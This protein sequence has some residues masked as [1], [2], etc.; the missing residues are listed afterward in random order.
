MG[1]RPPVRALHWNFIFV[2]PELYYPCISLVLVLDARL[3]KY[4]LDRKRSLEVSDMICSPS[5]GSD[6]VA[7]TCQSCTELSGA[8]RGGCIGTKV[9]SEV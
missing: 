1:H 6:S 2:Y 4:F 5:C 7:A 9:L 3:L 8:G